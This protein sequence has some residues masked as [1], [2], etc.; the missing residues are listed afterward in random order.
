MRRH[1]SVSMLHRQKDE[2]LEADRGLGGRQICMYIAEEGNN[3]RNKMKMENRGDPLAS[4]NLMPM[5]MG[6][7]CSHCF[8]V[9]DC[10]CKE[11]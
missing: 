2:A 1:S 5:P 9:L 3:A 6:S 7:L 11:S 8:D 10:L 4:L